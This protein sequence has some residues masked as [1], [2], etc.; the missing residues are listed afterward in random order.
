MSPKTVDYH[1]QKVFRKY[2]VSS[3]RALARRHNADGT[4]H[5]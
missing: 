2:G 5:G 3:R 1:L 4:A